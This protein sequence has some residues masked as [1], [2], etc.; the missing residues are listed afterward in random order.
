MLAFILNVL[1]EQTG[2][3]E[4][5]EIARQIALVGAVI[6]ALVLLC[7]TVGGRRDHKREREIFDDL[8]GPR[9]PQAPPES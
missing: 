4:V 2:A 6:V 9:P 5:R 3:E 8:Q 7:V 1:A